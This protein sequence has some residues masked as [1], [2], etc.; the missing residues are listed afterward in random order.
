MIREFDNVYVCIGAKYDTVK[1]LEN[2]QPWQI[3][4]KAK[5]NIPTIQLSE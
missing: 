3:D 1:P 2:V 5:S 4:V